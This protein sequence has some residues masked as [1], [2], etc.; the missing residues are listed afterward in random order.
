LGREAAVQLLRK[1]RHGVAGPKAGLDVPDRDALVE[2]GQTHRERGRGVTL[3]EH[4]VGLRF[5][6]HRGHSIENA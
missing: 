4:D 2:A 3:H 1:W 6:K 5:G